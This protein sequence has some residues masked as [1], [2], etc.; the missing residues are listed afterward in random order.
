[1]PGW[2]PDLRHVDIINPDGVIHHANRIQ[3]TVAVLWDSARLLSKTN[4]R[5]LGKH[6]YGRSYSFLVAAFGADKTGTSIHFVTR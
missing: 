5:F 6:Q 2:S 1:M 4:F 3:K